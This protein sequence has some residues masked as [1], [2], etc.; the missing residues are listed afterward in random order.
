MNKPLASIA[1]PAFNPRYFRYAIESA[2]FQTYDKCEIVVCD[3]SDNNEIYNITKQY[4]YTEKV[5][6]YRNP[7]N[8]GGRE[9]LIKCFE[10]TNGD[11]IKFLND[12]DILNTECVERMGNILINM[13]N[14][15]LVTSYRQCIDENGNELHDIVSTFPIVDESSILDG[16]NCCKLILKTK[17]NFIGEPSTT[18]FRKK[19]LEGNLPDILS[20]AGKRITY[21]VDVAMWL[22]LLQKGNLVYLTEP[23]SCFRL[24]KEQVQRRKGAQIKGLIAWAMFATLANKIGL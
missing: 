4:F 1:I 7:C 15:A 14:V 21:N 19:D 18:L 13:Q 17:I 9:N 22:Y 20:F 12:D 3:D 8:L 24:H 23:L 10:Q 11:F 2:V 5:R 16:V 6:Y